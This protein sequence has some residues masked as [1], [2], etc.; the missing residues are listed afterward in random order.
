MKESCVICGMV[1]NV[2]PALHTE[3]Y[4][5]VPEVIRDGVRRRFSFQSWTFQPVAVS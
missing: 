3:R 2:D 5:H 1:A 4:G